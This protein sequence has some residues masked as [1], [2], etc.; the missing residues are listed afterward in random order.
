MVFCKIHLNHLDFW[1]SYFIQ[2]WI[3]K[4]IYSWFCLWLPICFFC[5]QEVVVNQIHWKQFSDFW[6]M[7]TLS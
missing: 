6:K 1:F 5:F 4:I 3:S 2:P 7:A